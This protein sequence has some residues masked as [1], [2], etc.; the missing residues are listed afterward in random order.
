MTEICHNS[1]HFRMEGTVVHTVYL[2]YKKYCICL[3]IRWPA[4]KIFSSQE[5][6]YT[7]C[8]YRCVQLKGDP[9]SLS[10][11][12]LYNITILCSSKYSTCFP[13]L[14]HPS[15]DESTSMV[16]HWC[17]FWYLLNIIQNELKETQN[18]KQYFTGIK[19]C[20]SC[21]PS[22]YLLF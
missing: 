16:Q 5:N 7:E 10:D 17:K 19:R 1:V 9:P 11:H 2:H 21:Q 14:C 20:S 8:A 18:D 13:H 6:I 12:E 4:F 3:N 22:E 15:D